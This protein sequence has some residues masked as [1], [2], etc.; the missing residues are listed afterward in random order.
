MSDLRLMVTTAVGD[1]RDD[2]PTCTSRI[3][4]GGDD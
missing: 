2:A 4:R 1:S 3:G